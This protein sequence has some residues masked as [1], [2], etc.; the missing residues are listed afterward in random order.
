MNLPEKRRKAETNLRTP[1][2]TPW[3]YAVEEYDL[4][5][6]GISSQGLRGSA[7]SGKL[8]HAAAPVADLSAG[9]DLHHRGPGVPTRERKSSLFPRPVASISAWPKR[10]EELPDDYQPIDRQ[11]DGEAA[12]HRTGLRSAVGDGE[13]IHEGASATW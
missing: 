1:E 9:P 6:I 13:A 12:R 5:P 3:F 11:W 4:T 7:L 10:C 8:G 2:V